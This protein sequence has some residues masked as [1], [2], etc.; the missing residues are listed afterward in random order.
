[1]SVKNFKKQITCLHDDAKELWEIEQTLERAKKDIVH[2]IERENAEFAMDMAMAKGFPDDDMNRAFIHRHMYRPIK[3][4]YMAG[5]IEHTCWRHTFLM[6]RDEEGIYAYYKEESRNSI[7]FYFTDAIGETRK[8]TYTGP[9]FI[10]CDH[11]CSHG[12]NTHGAA[13]GCAQQDNHRQNV[14]QNCISG[15]D[16]ADTMFVWIDQ[17]FL[18]AH[19]T[20]SEIGYAFAK[21]KNII[22]GVHPS[23][24]STRDV[25]FC[26]QMATSIIIADTPVAA[27]GDYFP[28]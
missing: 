19:G 13:F 14:F 20:I 15:I 12:E 26:S 6:L 4:I 3:S 24:V 16:R 25:W 8:L 27:L 2:D 5:K 22:F 9:F 10:A 11:G 28:R 23:M 18:S 1:M 17:A 21:N 7:P